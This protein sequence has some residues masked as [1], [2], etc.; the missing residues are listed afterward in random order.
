M[1]IMLD[2]LLIVGSIVLL[3]WATVLASVVRASAATATWFPVVLLNTAGALILTTAIVLIASFRRPRS[4]ATL[5]FLGTGL[6]AQALSTNVFVYRV[7][8]GKISAPPWGQLGYTVAFL[9]IFL[10]ALVPIP[11]PMRADTPDSPSPR[12]MWAHA[13]L[14][15]VALAAAGL[16]IAGKLL[17]G[18]PLDRF[19]A[20]GMVSLILIALARQMLTLAE[21]TWLL[22]E[23]REREQQLHYQAFHDPL[24][25]LANRALFT[26]RLRRALAPPD[27]HDDTDTANTEDAAPVAVLFLDLDRFKWVNDTYGHAAGDELLKISAQRL[28]AQTPGGGH[29]R[30]D[31]R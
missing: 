16:L 22:A 26:R 27:P 4:P 29:R 2:C 9:L 14:P 31:R 1:I 25:G 24:T 7:A 18:T 12:S 23:V 10:A 17:T 13:A 20:Y 15:Y 28:Q 3:E 19:E 11:S 8:Q 21:N 6:L 30:P 5:A